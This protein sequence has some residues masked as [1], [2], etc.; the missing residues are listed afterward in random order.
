[1]LNVTVLVD[2]AGWIGVV[3]LLAAY[4]LVSTRRLQG[5]SV[6]YQSLNVAGS[7]LLI[8]NSFYYGALPS[9]GVNLAWIGIGL[10]A[11]ARKRLSRP[12]EL[13]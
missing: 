10:Y 7:A 8:L 4:A 6:A 1:M 9:V 13:A 12:K 5:D 3:T 2:V 11:L